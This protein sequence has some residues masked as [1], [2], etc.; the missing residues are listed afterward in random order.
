MVDIQVTGAVTKIRMYL[1]DRVFD[2]EITQ[3]DWASNSSV[4]RS[5]DRSDSISE[6][7]FY[8]RLSLLDL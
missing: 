7:G 6:P 3:K 4:D 5:D 8:S 2:Y 1:E